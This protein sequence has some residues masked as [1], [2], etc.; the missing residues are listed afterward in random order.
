MIVSVFS[1]PFLFALVHSCAAFRPLQEGGTEN[2]PEE[3]SK[4]SSKLRFPRSQDG[5]EDSSGLLGQEFGETTSEVVFLQAI[6]ND[7]EPHGP[8]SRGK[9]KIKLAGDRRL[10]PS[11]WCGRDDGDDEGLLFRCDD[12]RLSAEEGTVFHRYARD[13]ETRVL[14]AARSSRPIDPKTRAVPKELLPA[15]WRSEIDCENV[16]FDGLVRNYMEN[17]YKT[18]PWLTDCYA[19]AEDR[20]VLGK[21]SFGTVVAARAVFE[22]DPK[23]V[24]PDG[25]ESW[26]RHFVVKQV[27]YGGTKPFN[28]IRNEM[29]ILQLLKDESPYLV[30][31]HGGFALG[32]RPETV[33]EGTTASERKKKNWWLVF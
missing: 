31:F 32:Y 8:R 13:M 29:A 28:D 24:G 1:P 4:P 3:S 10:P 7:D 15:Y 33:K 19:L 17:W 22:P 11:S 23:V 2:R 25:K 14:N 5:L 30:K 12:Y 26:T 18:W 27:K 9:I 6:A 16:G 21:G 20:V